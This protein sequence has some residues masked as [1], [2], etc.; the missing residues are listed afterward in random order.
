MLHIHNIT[1]LLYYRRTKDIKIWDKPQKI[2]FIV[3]VVNFF[4][5]YAFSSSYFRYYFPYV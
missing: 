3:G 5:L 1:Y 4:I 2:I